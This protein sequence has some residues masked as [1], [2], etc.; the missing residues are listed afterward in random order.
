M[1][2]SVAGAI[3]KVLV[4]MLMDLPERGPQLVKSRVYYPL[5]LFHVG[6]NDMACQKLGKIKEDYT[7]LGMQVK[8]I[9]AQVIFSSILTVRGRSAA[10]NRRI[11]QINYWFCGW[12][13]REGF[14]FYDNGTFFDDGSLLGRHGIHLSRR[15]KGILGSRLS[16]LVR[17]A[18]N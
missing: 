3:L 14:G 7:A 12:C 5:L 6:T 18:L 16:N 15:G 17:Q 13:R 10:R 9:A 8:N 11:L 1:A 2:G 4:S